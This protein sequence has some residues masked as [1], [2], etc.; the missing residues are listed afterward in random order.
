MAPLSLVV[1]HHHRVDAE[2]YGLRLLEPETPKEKTEQQPAEEPDPG[3]PKGPEEAFDRVRGCHVVGPGFDGSSVAFVRP[4]FVEANQVATRAV[5]KK[6]EELVEEGDDSKTLCALA[7]PT[8]KANEVGKDPD[9]MQVAAE[10]SQ[11]PPAGQGI[12]RNG[13]GVE[14]GPL[15][16]ARRE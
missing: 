15:C 14:M 4:E 5:Q 13:Y 16:V 2:K 11:A 12:G 9:V 3:P 1:V 7:H 10:E 8:E 6:T